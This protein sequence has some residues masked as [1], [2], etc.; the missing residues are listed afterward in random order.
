MKG[1]TWESEMDGDLSVIESIRQRKTNVAILGLGR[2]GLPTALAFANAGFHV[3][4]AEIDQNKVDAL[5]QGTSYITEPGIQDTLRACLEKGTFSATSSISDAVHENDIVSICVPT[6]VKNSVPN[7]TIFEAAFEEVKR[8][9]HRNLVVLI[10]STLPPSTTSSFAVPQLEALGYR[11][12]GD[13]F[14]AYCPE[15]LAPTLALKEFKN[16]TRI[17]GGV[18]PRSGRIAKEFYDTVCREVVLTSALTAEMSKVAENTFRDLNIAYANL[19]ALISEHIGADVLEIIALANTHPRVSIHEPGLGVGGPC[20]PKDPYLL[21]Y[22]T[23]PN[24]VELVK[25]GRLLNDYMP[26]H[27]IEI[28]MNESVRGGK[29]IRN[30]K[31]AVL[32]VTYKADIDDVTNSPAKPLIEDLLKNGASVTVYDPHT[33]ITFGAERCDSV[34]QAILDADWIV[35]ATGH[36]CFRFL[37]SLLEKNITKP[38]CAIFDGSR[39]LDRKHVRSLGLK[40]FGTGYGPSLAEHA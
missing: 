37:G 4:G 14:L 15:R 32:G 35:I 29:E 34:Q 24:M 10:E 27:V 20:I 23:P 1:A 18:G 3:T 40:Y 17:V 8:G 38:H 31:V 11:V 5:R 30:S 26:K 2:V 9:A 7:L 16:T 25:Q 21:M 33:L 36:Q 6:P 13:I 12:D 22:G 19:L 28:M 39:V